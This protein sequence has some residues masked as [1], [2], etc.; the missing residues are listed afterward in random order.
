MQLRLGGATRIRSR[1]S[2]YLR[3]F[4]VSR[5]PAAKAGFFEKDKKVI[6]YNKAYQFKEYKRR[7]ILLLAKQ[8]EKMIFVA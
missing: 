1:S 8:S 4:P 5:R 2:G 7:S 6:S 3:F